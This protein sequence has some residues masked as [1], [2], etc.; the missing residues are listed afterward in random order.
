MPFTLRIPEIAQRDRFI[1]QTIANRVVFALAKEGGLARVASRSCRKRQVTLLWSTRAQAQHWAPIIAGNATVSELP[2][3]AV[4][5]NVLPELAGLGRLVGPDW[6]ADPAEAEIDPAELAERL[7]LRALEA[8]VTRARLAGAVWILAD[9]SGPALLVSDTRP[10]RFV[11]PC[12]SDRGSAAS[13]RDGPWSD[14]SASPLVLETFVGTT[15]PWLAERGWLV[16]PEHAEGPGV[17]ELDPD[18][19]SPRLAPPV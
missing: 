3:T 17:L 15:L 4:L 19:L 12:W 5:S 8:F 6:C 10:D 16:S 14:T 2:L 18:Q 13:R 11:L 9:A 1:R 7:R